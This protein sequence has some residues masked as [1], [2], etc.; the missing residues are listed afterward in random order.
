MAEP[1]RRDDAAVQALRESFRRHM[2]SAREATLASR[3]TGRGDTRP[4]VAP[5]PAND[6]AN[7]GGGPSPLAQASGVQAVVVSRPA[8]TIAA[9][10]IWDEPR[11]TPA[12]R[13]GAGRLPDQEDDG[14]YED[15]VTGRPRRAR[16][17]LAS[18]LLTG[19]AAAVL[20]GLGAGGYLAWNAYGTT[21]LDLLAEIQ[22]S[23]NR[24][25]PTLVQTGDGGRVTAAPA[26][27]PARPATQT[28][29][30]SPAGTRVAAAEPPRAALSHTVRTSAIT[31]DPIDLAVQ[32]AREH[33]AGGNAADARLILEPYRNSNDPRALFALA[34][35]YDPGFERDPGLVDARQ[36]QALYTAAGKAG[37]T[38]AAERLSR[39]KMD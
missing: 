2:E 3:S 8:A 21:A 19:L 20:L 26:A 24:P 13:F 37:N 17:G 7:G 5:P 6:R 9:D 12:T 34:E 15:A 38:A 28:P 31:L 25:G 1:L 4:L 29:S 11:R 36:A 14:T 35:T 22:N 23:Q 18:V 30:P 32:D 27:T 16:S 39:L 10:E 33:M